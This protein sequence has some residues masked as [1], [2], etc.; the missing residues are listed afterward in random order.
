MTFQFLR[1]AG[2]CARI[3]GHANGIITVTAIVQRMNVSANGV[4]CPTMARPTT[5]L[6]DQKNDVRVRRRYGEAWNAGA[7]RGIERGK[8]SQRKNHERVGPFSHPDIPDAVDRV[9]HG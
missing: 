3:S 7:R 2:Q 1:T 9:G 5:Q 4:T 8:L 6:S